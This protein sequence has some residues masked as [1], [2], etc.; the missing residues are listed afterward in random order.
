[1]EQILTRQE[2]GKLLPFARR[3]ELVA[4]MPEMK[5]KYPRYSDYVG[6]GI[7]DM[8]TPT[9]LE[10]S[11]QLKATNLASMVLLSQPNGQYIV[12]DLP[13]LAQFFSCLWFISQ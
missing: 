11:M 12:K 10:E 8:F 1:I 13:A 9:Q 3:H 6:Q 4:Q 7:H 5:K 2:D